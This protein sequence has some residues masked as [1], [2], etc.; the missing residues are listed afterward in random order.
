MSLGFMV[1]ISALGL[2][3]QNMGD[4]YIKNFVSQAEAERMVQ[5][6]QYELSNKLKCEAYLVGKSIGPLDNLSKTGA[7]KNLVGTEEKLVHGGVKVAQLNLSQMSPSML[8]LEIEF[9]RVNPK[10]AVKSFRR[11]IQIQAQVE[12]GSVT[13]CF[14]NMTEAIDEAKESLCNDVNGIFDTNTKTCQHSAVGVTPC[15]AGQFIA[16]LNYN[17]TT[18]TYDPVCQNLP[19]FATNC[20]LAAGEIAHGYD[21]DN[22]FQCRQVTLQDIQDNIS[23][24]QKNCTNF[25]QLGFES[26][27]AIGFGCI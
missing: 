26:L 2:R 10:S 13:S 14:S 5:M 4:N 12:G 11:N 27:G 18:N 9:E 1:L 24:A 16:G 8:N 23:T 17:S 25:S 21:A 3:I 7:S 6:I 22:G 19:N 20:N 15:G